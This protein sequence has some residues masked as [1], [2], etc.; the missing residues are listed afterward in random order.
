MPLD[1][2]PG[3]G[4]LGSTESG[5]RG[6][7]FSRLNGYQTVIADP[8]AA[9]EDKAYALFR[10]INCYGPSGYNSCGGRD[11]A[12]SVRKGWF[13]QLKTTYGSTSWAKSLQ[14]YW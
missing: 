13:K 7:L 8:K 4:Q 5:F 11:V 2:R 12:Q 14:Y 9:R 1:Q 6:E 10:A 3:A